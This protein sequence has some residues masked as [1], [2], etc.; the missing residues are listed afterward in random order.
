MEN[1]EKLQRIYKECIEEL[2]SIG[3]QFKNKEINIQ[4]SK[5][6]NKRYGC[7]K[8]EK[9]DESYKKIER[10]GFRYIIKYGNYKKYTIEISPWVM[11]LKEEIIKNTIIHELIHC[12]PYCTNH[13]NEFKRYAKIVKEKLGYEITRT[14]NKKEDFQKSNI[15]YKEND[16][17]KYKIICKECGQVY[18]RKRLNKNFTKKY[19][20]KCKG[21]LEIV[22]E[23]K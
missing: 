16:D 12:I 10:K 9:P 22:E 5:R 3:I 20:C 23:I 2:D 4:I 21:K 13:G 6:N 8:P 19:R 1:E 11:E 17:Y 15:K 18:Y 7:C 14:G